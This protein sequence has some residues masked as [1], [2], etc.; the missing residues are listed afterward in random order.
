MVLIQGRLL[1]AD[2]TER[3]RVLRLFTPAG[4]DVVVEVDASP[5][6]PLRPLDEGAQRM[7]AARRRGLL[8]PAEIIKLLAP[9]GSQPSA[10]GQPAGAFVEHDLDEEEDWY[11]SSVRRRRTRRGSSSACCATSPSATRRAWSG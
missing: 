1:E 10:P 9:A 4:Q 2:G 3:D 5:S 6:E 8:H 7:I 11:R